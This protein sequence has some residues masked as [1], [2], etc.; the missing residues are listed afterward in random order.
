MGWQT[1]PKAHCASPT[2]EAHRAS[3]TL[4]NN[5]RVTRAQTHRVGSEQRQFFRSAHDRGST[6][7]DRHSQSY[8]PILY[9][10]AILG[11]FE[12]TA[13]FTSSQRLIALQSLVSSQEQQL[14]PSSHLPCF[15][16][17]ELFAILD[18]F[19]CL[20]VGRHPCISPNG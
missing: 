20:L 4:E 13:P 16:L 17:L 2:L 9:L 14:F 18:L 7:T 8:D 10:F 15:P 12:R 6:N 5:Q 1:V 3:P 19:A 11:L